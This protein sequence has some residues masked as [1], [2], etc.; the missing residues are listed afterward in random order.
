[1]IKAVI[2]GIG[3]NFFDGTLELKVIVPLPEEPLLTQKAT[4]AENV[5]ADREYED[6]LDKALKLVKVGAVLIDYISDKAEA[7]ELMSRCE[8]HPE[9]FE[10]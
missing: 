4:E 8:P 2:K 6:A 5:K 3:H 7:R 10:V 9:L 1:M